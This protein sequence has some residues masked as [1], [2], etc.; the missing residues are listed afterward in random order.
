MSK[1]PSLPTACWRS[2]EPVEEGWRWP[3]G[4]MLLW[5]TMLK[6]R[7]TYLVFTGRIHLAGEAISVKISAFLLESPDTSATLV[8][9]VQEMGGR[10]LVFW[11]NVISLI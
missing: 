10:A 1:G 6:S 3:C 4:G 7:C 11:C 8:W 5:L 9:R 2:A